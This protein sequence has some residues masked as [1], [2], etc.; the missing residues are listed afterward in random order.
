MTFWIYGVYVLLEVPGSLGVQQQY[1]ITVLNAYAEDLQDN[2]LALRQYLRGDPVG[3]HFDGLSELI[4]LR[5]NSHSF[6]EFK[7]QNGVVLG[8]LPIDKVSTYHWENMLSFTPD[9]QG[10]VNRASCSPDWTDIK[11][12]PSSDC[13]TFSIF[14]IYERNRQQ[15][16]NNIGF[17]IIVLFVMLVGLGLLALDFNALLGEP[18]KTLISLIKR[19][20]KVYSI[21][22]AVHHHDIYCIGDH[23]RG[24]PA[25]FF[26]HQTQRRR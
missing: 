1:G 17:T 26:Y 18:I 7:D 12:L 21:A 2:T 24:G 20:Q 8:S 10:Y 19:L 6:N 11:D 5:V 4:Y 9:E 14:S 13:R 3:S 22:Q 25:Q 16:L 23:T 15:A